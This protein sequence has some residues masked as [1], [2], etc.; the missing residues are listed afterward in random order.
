MRAIAAILFAAALACGPAAAAPP[1]KTA[2][3]LEPAMQV[4]V[5]RS[6]HPG[7]EP[8]CPQWIAAQGRIVPGTLGQFKKVLRGLGG[9]K[10]P[11]FVDSSGGAV[12][13]ALA[14]GRLIRAKG[15]HVAVTRTTFTPCAPGDAACRRA[16]SSGELRGVAQAYFSK[17]ASSC[18]FILA[19]GTRRFVGQGTGVGVHRISMTLRMYRILTRYTLGGRVERRKTLVSERKVGEKHAQTRSAY[20]NIGRYFA[21]MGI[22]GEIMPLILS[23][24]SDS[25]RW[26]TP[27][28]LRSTGLATHPIGGEQ[29]VTE[30]AAPTPAA[31]PPAP[32]PDGPGR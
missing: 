16:K 29:L 27:E 22:G 32:S 30:A 7:C 13:D 6:A 1:K 14:I 12:N 3:L 31:L 11:I 28:E 19:G 18:A 24:P 4:H 21:E 2:A 23:T 9:R 25:I 5:V 8:E 20:A 26:L 17:C 10:L 15:L